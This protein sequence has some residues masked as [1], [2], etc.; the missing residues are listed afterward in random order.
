MRSVREGEVGTVSRH[1]CTGDVETCA[2]CSRGRDAIEDGRHGYS[3][4]E[5]GDMA[6]GAAADMVFGR[7]W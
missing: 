4:A 2:I 6:D 7:E 1:P 5:L 3:D